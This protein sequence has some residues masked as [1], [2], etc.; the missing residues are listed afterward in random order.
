MAT[1]CWPLAEILECVRLTISAAINN[2]Q[3][4]CA[5]AINQTNMNRRSRPKL[6]EQITAGPCP[7]C[8]KDGMEG[9]S[10]QIAQ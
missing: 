10:A 8:G 1:F 3:T 2:K 7:G 5:E 9:N 4:F 6:G